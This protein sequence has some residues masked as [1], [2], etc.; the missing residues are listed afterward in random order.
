MRQD[1]EEQVP[2][3]VTRARTLVIVT[4]LIFQAAIFGGIGM[5]AYRDL[6]LRV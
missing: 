3:I 4:F 6:K 1:L 5:A 2:R